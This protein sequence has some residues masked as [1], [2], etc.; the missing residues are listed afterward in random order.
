MGKKFT[1]SM[2]LVDSKKSYEISEAIDVMKKAA[3]AK[4]DESVDLAMKL[5]ADP[6]KHSIRGTVMLPGGSGKSK[7][8]AVITKA[9][10]VKEVEAA[11]ADLVG[12]DDLVEKIQKGFLDF[13][14]LIVSPDMMAAVGKLGK[15]LGPK[16]LM[17][18]PKTGTVT[19]ELAKAV[20]EFKSG[21]V[22]FRMDK[23][24]ALHIILG[25]L[26]FDAA[27]LKKN[28][29]AVVAAIMATKPSGLKTAFVQSMA[30]SSTMGPGIKLVVEKDAING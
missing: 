20:Q 21:K 23:G 14:V 3:F 4:F 18:N 10:K 1:A 25:K 26:S 6:K 9:D 30:I 7:K 24:G 5:S 13:D 11:G 8:I 2:K 27:N 28:F 12:S 22:E 15:V 16:G 17:P 29:E 19:P